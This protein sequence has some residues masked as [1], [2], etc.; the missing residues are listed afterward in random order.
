MKTTAGLTFL[1][2]SLV[3]EE[4]CISHFERVNEHFVLV[5]VKIR[6]NACFEVDTVQQFKKIFRE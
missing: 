2:P 6:W 3:V 1:G 5:E 4:S